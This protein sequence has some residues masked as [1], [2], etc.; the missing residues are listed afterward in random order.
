MKMIYDFSFNKF[1]LY[2]EEIGFGVSWNNIITDLS[3]QN[4]TYNI[5]MRHT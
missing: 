5:V 2:N 1:Y 3:L 4:K